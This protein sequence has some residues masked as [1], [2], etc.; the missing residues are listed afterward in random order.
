MTR[1]KSIISSNKEYCIQ[2]H[3]SQLG[4]RKFLENLNNNLLNNYKLNSVHNSFYNK[5]SDK[6]INDSELLIKSIT[7]QN[8]NSILKAFAETFRQT[9]HHD[10][11]PENQK[12]PESFEEFENI[13]SEK[14]KL[15][16]QKDQSGIFSNFKNKLINFFQSKG[17]V[18]Q[19]HSNEN[20]NKPKL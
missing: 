3:A 9:Y 11:I 12:L 15:P 14:Y 20:D 7:A 4:D 13:N 2:M 6:Y 19:K 5:N 1:I 17:S 16:A 18:D 10:K 8:Y